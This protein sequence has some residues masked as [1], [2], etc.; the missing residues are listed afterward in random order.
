[1]TDGELFTTYTYDA[2]GR[3][4][5]TIRPNGS[6]SVYEYNEKDEIV[7]LEN[8]S[9]DDKVESSFK[10][11]Y[12]AT[13]NIVKEEAKNDTDSAVRTYEYNEADELTGF[14][15]KSAETNVEYRYE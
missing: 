15:E 6:K 14:T 12:D 7:R 8:R 5:E 1:M 10:Y 3:M 13:G 4:T 2:A 9:N 11:E